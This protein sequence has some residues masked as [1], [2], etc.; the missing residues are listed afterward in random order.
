LEAG[1]GEEG[2]VRA[3]I[4]AAFGALDDVQ[5]V[6][7]D[8]REATRV[9]CPFCGA[10]VMREATLCFSCWRRLAPSAGS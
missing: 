3:A 1:D 10:R 6:V 7:T 5:T 9:A 8:P 4:A 2:A